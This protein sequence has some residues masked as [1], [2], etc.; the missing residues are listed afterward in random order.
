MS[1]RSP[2]RLSQQPE[3]AASRAGTTVSPARATPRGARPSGPDADCVPATGDH[4]AGLVDVGADFFTAAELAALEL[5]GLPKRREHIARLASKRG[6][7]HRTRSGRGGGREFSLSAL[8]DAARGEVVRR[9]LLNGA[10]TA[11]QDQRLAPAVA[12]F[13]SRQA[14]RFAARSLL[15]AAFDRFKDG[16]ADRAMIVPFLD[17]FRSGLVDLPAWAR[18]RLSRVG[19]RTLEEWLAA[20][21][22]G[23][24]QVLAGADRQ[25]RKT[26]IE[27]SGEAAD[28]LVGAMIDQPHLSR[29]QLAQLLAVEFEGGVPD[30]NGLLMP[31]PGERAIGRFVA[32]WLDD[33]L[34]R[35]TMVS[36]TDPDRWKSHYR[37][38]GGDASA[39]IVR[40]NQ[41]WQID[42]S[43]ADAMCTD[44]RY[45]IY[46]VIDIWSRRMMALV[47]RTPK[48]VAALLLI[49]RACVAWGVPEVLVTDNGSDFASFHFVDAVLRLGIQLVP[50]PPYTPEKKAFIERGIGTVQRGLMAML[51]GFKGHNVAQ[52]SQIRARR[53]FSNRLGESDDAL[54]SVSL[55]GGELQERLDAW[56]ANVY[57]RT[58]HRGI[59]TTPELRALLGAE[60][61]PP[62]FANEAAIGMLLMAPPSDGP[63]RIVTKK[64]VAVAGLDYWCD[65]LLTG[66]R[67][68]VRLDPA[69]LGQV[70]LY[71]DTNPWAFLG[72]AQ[73]P[74]VAGID[75]AELTAR[76][77]AAQDDLVR[78][79]RSN[80]RALRRKTDLPAVVERL[81]GLPPAQ[82]P[83]PADAAQH[84]T[85]DLVEAAIAAAADGARPKRTTKPVTEEEAAEHQ[86]FVADFRT[87]REQRQLEETAEDRYARW[88]KLGELVAAGGAISP[89]SREWFDVYATTPECKG[90]RLVEE[91]FGSA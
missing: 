36:L 5:P 55:S 51:P 37:F 3:P 39:G 8:P 87:A 13:K 43:P 47:S 69:D 76:V 56:L 45:S 78:G 44:G 38:A 16:A 74:D 75:R 12:G 83:A 2:I 10:S 70:Y 29:A 81:I 60:A 49:K 32:R 63:T 79:H 31:V 65:R 85:P 72:I 68:Q 15:L 17:A 84:D 34:N 57:A 46:V 22:A 61:H 80:L 20:R 73:N 90:R 9:R 77:R 50:A 42:A 27:C 30:D 26:V 67:V 7:E 40:L 64:G 6:W 14:E 71:T 82:I 89:D 48:T 4:P 1:R 11:D 53:S 58:P 24:A 19:R 23:R 66:Q 18:A 91:E 21:R 41:R 86:A 52:A 35:Q 59:G 33:P 62:K 25:G 28:W 88:K 54:F